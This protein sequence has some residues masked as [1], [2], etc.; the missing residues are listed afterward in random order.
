MNVQGSYL[1]HKGHPR[2][3][4]DHNMLSLCIALQRLSTVMGKC[5]NLPRLDHLGL[6]CK[7]LNIHPANPLEELPSFDFH[8]SE[9]TD[10]TMDQVTA[11]EGLKVLERTTESWRYIN[12]NKAGTFEIKDILSFQSGASL[13]ASAKPK[14]PYCSP[15]DCLKSPYCFKF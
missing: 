13:L 10:S 7:E 15:L 14:L 3:C 12:V 5:R 1:R 11:C 4:Q 6:A 9:V 2:L 8:V